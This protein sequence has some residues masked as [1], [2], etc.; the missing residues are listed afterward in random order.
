MS[1]SLARIL[2]DTASKCG[3]RV[4]FKL[5]DVELTYGNARRGPAPGS[6]ACS[7]RRGSSRATASGSCCRT[8]RTSP[9]S[10]TGPA[11]RR[12]VVPMNVLL[13]G[14]RSVLPQ[15]PGAR[16]VFAW[17]DFGTR[18]DRRRRGRRRGILVKPGEF[19][20]LSSAAP[21]RGAGRPRDGDDTAVILYTSG[22][23]GTPK[24]AEL[25]HANLTRNCESVGASLAEITEDDVL[26]GALPLFHSFGQTCTHE[27]DGRHRRD[28]HDASAL[29]PGEGARSFYKQVDNLGCSIWS[30]YDNRPLCHLC[31]KRRSRNC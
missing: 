22:T 1:E 9:S 12:V 20:Q 3:D 31:R 18:P 11:R 8:C 23:T 26:L 17:H 10:T 5:D 16:L 27:R 21:R 24:G 6:P 14:A 4:A 25:S 7:P 30:M 13:K 2:T 19:E 15:D 28:G 29:R